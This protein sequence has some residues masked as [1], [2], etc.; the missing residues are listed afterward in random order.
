[1]VWVPWPGMV[2]VLSAAGLVC[3]IDWVMPPVWD[4]TGTKVSVQLFCDE[5]S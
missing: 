4:W 5:G 2:M 3:V 1:V